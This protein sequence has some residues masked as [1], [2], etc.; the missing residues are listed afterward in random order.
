VRG[1]LLEN[2]ERLLEAVLLEQVEGAALDA[3]DVQR[4]ALLLACGIDTVEQL[5]RLVE[6]V[7]R[8]QTSD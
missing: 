1:L 3:L 5:V 7:L 2:F 8:D 6:L 4:A